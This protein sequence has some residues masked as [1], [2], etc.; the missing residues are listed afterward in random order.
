M[1]LIINKKNP[2]PRAYE[3]GVG[4]MSY[5]PGFGGCV[6]F[7]SPLAHCCC[8]L[9]VSSWALSSVMLSPRSWCHCRCGSPPVVV[10]LS[11]R[12]CWVV[13][14]L[15]ASVNPHRPIASPIHPANSR[16]Q[17]WRWVLGFLSSL[18]SSSCSRR[19]DDM[20]VSTRNPTCE[21]WLAA[22]GRVLGY[23]G[24]VLVGVAVVIPR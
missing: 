19:C 20:A 11:P 12:G 17:R 3:R 14:L 1:K 22:R 18:V 2:P 16:S 8:G 5:W 23:P 24:I 6:S 15:A 10:P 13:V 7:S 9:G 21:Q 4:V